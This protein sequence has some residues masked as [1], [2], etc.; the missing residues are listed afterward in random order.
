MQILQIIAFCA[1]LIVFAVFAKANFT[2]SKYRNL[3]S[4]GTLG[5]WTGSINIDELI[6]QK[7]V[8]GNLVEKQLLKAMIWHKRSK[9]LLYLG[10]GINLALVLYASLR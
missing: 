8:S 9:N 10:L 7:P 2:I 4:M 1:V 6:K 5:L 3:T